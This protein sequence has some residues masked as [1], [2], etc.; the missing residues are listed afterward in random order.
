MLPP[1]ESLLIIRL[2][3]AAAW[4][5]GKLHPAE[6]AALRRLID[7][8]D[9][10][11]GDQRKEALG[12]LTAAPRIDA[13]EV[14]KL[15]RDAREGVYRAALG[16]IRLDHQVTDEE[17]R[18]VEGLRAAIDLDDQLVAAIDR[19]AADPPAGD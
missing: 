7:A 14:R 17:R 13:A 3:A 16:I 10:L 19:E 8:S 6:A 15:R 12:L 5:D 2:W 18:W 1:M 4:A 11:G 9:D